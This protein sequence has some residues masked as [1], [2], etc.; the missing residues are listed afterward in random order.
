VV[1]TVARYELAGQKVIEG[2]GVEPD[3]AVGELPEPPEGMA[4][5]ELGLWLRQ[6]RAEVRAEQLQAALAA[7]RGKLEG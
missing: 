2:A 6:R 1:L 5:R 4:G 3:V 7:V